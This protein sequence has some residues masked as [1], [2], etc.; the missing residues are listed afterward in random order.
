MLNWFVC[1]PFLQCPD[2]TRY[3]QEPGPTNINDPSHTE[4][5]GRQSWSS[6]SH[7]QKDSWGSVDIGYLL[8]ISDGTYHSKVFKHAGKGT[9]MVLDICQDLQRGNS[10]TMSNPVESI[11]YFI[12]NHKHS[13]LGS[14]MWNSKGLAVQA[15]FRPLH[16]SLTTGILPSTRSTPQRPRQIRLTRAAFK[17]PQWSFPQQAEKGYIN[18]HKTS[19]CPRALFTLTLLS[20]TPT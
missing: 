14:A 15:H 9:R 12:V 16:F 6:V 10:Q 4:I 5:P 13:F 1:I 7:Q 8:W 2:E 19:I 18:Y 20:H 17:I 11:T 3:S